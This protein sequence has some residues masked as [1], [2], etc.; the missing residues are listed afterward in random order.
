MLISVINFTRGKISDEELQ[1]N[2]RAVNR[3]IAEDFASYWSMGAQLRVDGRSVDQ[4]DAATFA[5]LR[6]DAILYVTDKANMPGALG[7]HDVNF[8]G[9]PFGFVFTDFPPEFGP[10]SVTLSHEALELIADPEVNLLVIG[11]HPD[12]NEDRDVFV[13]YEMC[14]A[15]QSESYKIDGVD[16]SNFVLPLYFTG[17]RSTD[18][19]G[20]RNDFLGREPLL[21]SFSVK[22]GGYAGF[23]DPQTGKMET[24]A[25]DK[26]AKARLE[27]KEALIAGV[28]GGVEA[29]RT[30]RHLNIVFK[31][32]PTT[33]S[34]QS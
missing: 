34:P 32:A 30:G 31:Q 18:E 20:A 25:A 10:W 29:T 1:C 23:F 11:P 14:D 26:K 3:Q 6:G 16:V 19:P 27:A 12:P 2:V 24:F 17:T 7:F 15:V 28:K 4:P 21:K 5:D 33:P 9:V 13:W 8:S 22:P